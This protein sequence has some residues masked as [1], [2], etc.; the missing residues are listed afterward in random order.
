[1]FFYALP[2]AQLEAHSAEERVLEENDP[3]TIFYTGD[4]LDLLPEIQGTLMLAVPMKPL[5]REDC[6]G[7]CPQCG[8]SLSEGLCACTRENGD[9]PFSVLK[10]FKP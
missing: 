6:P 3:A 2:V 9:G 4:I 10:K 1:V 8:Q 5:C 7:L